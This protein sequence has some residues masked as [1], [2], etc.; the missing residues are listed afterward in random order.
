GRTPI[1]YAVQSSWDITELLLSVAG[2]KPDIPDKRGRT[3]L[4]YAVEGS[5]PNSSIVDMLLD[6]DDVNPNSYDSRGR[7][8]LTY[9]TEYHIFN[10]LIELPNIERNHVDSTGMTPLMHCPEQG[11]EYELQQ[12]LDRA[13]LNLDVADKRGRTL[14]MLCCWS[15]S[16]ERM[17]Q[18]FI[19]D[20]YAD[21]NARSKNQR[22]ALSWAVLR[23]NK[24]AVEILLQKYHVDPN[25]RDRHSC[26]PLYYAL[27]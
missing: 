18:R 25:V 4:S 14:L 23:G 8:P 6:R 13:N 9:A 20:Y 7:P 10:R 27:W 16:G 1:S 26:T 24:T 5:Y 21:P 2:I 19:E 12:F 17:V 3:P 22:T 11:F 15:G